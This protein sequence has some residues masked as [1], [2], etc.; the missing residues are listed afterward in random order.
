MLKICSE[1]LKYEYIIRI[2]IYEIKLFLSPIKIII[3]II[4][5]I[6]IQTILTMYNKIIKPCK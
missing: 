2:K 3:Y 1:I 5:L 4:K 6:I